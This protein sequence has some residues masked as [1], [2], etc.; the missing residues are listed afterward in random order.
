MVRY[1]I[2][3]KP[4]HTPSMIR[5]RVEGIPLRA[6]STETN[7]PTGIHEIHP[8]TSRSAVGCN[9]HNVTSYL[10]DLRTQVNS[11]KCSV[12]GIKFFNL[13]PLMQARDSIN[14]TNYMVCCTMIC[15]G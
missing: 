7:G 5:S 12:M 14:Q 6:T 2:L 15:H 1:L 8:V 11:T 9:I 10:N 13:Q 4:L 3:L